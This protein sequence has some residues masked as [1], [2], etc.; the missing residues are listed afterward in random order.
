MLVIIL[1]AKHL[2][3]AFIAQCANDQQDE[4]K[5]IN[6]ANILCRRDDILLSSYAFDRCRQL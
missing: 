4:S 3:V 5:R 1:E 2:L 6:A